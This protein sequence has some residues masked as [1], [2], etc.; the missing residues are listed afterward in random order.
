MEA[1]SDI[2]E[3]GHESREYKIFQAFSVIV[4][5]GFSFFSVIGLRFFFWPECIHTLTWVC[6]CRSF[7]INIA[8]C[9][10]CN[11]QRLR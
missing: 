5:V 10:I 1:H 9:C 8:V 6:T 2:C 3:G 11:S 4:G 7:L